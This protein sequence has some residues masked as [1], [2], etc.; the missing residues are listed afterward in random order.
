[1]SKIFCFGEL[2]LRMSP[3][4]G[5]EWIQHAAMPV[6][7][8]GAELNTATAL[9][10][11][12]LPVKYS[13]ALPDHYLSQE[14]VDYLQQKNIETSAIR[15]SGNRIGI[16]FLPQGADLKNSGVIYDRAHSSFA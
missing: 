2:L 15:I 10:G 4:L 6:Y 1:M 11:W 12:K 9:A 3:S 16:Y 13:T 14:I 7:P 8:G 5:Q